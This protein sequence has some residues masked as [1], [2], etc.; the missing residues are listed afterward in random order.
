MCNPTQ[1]GTV[2]EY[3]TLP[4][5]VTDKAAEAAAKEEAKARGE[6]AE[7]KPLSAINPLRQPSIGEFIFYALP[8]TYAACQ[9]ILK[10]L[11]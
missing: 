5:Y 2:L 6:E 11:R 4:D 1:T 3:L 8:F 7:E 9:N 10:K